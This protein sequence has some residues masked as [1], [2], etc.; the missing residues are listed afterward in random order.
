MKHFSKVREHVE[1]LNIIDDTLFQKM[2]ED[3][4]F[5]EEMISAVLSE[6]VQVVQSIPQGSVKNLQGRSVIVDALCEK[7][8]GTFINVEV[9]KN[10]DDNHQKRI[11]YNASCIT[12]NITDPGIKFEKVPDLIII[13]ISQFDMFK[14]KKIIYHVDRMVREMKTKVSNG[15][16]EIYV[17]TR[18]VDGSD[19]AELMRIYTNVDAYDYIKFPNTSKRKAHFKKNEEGVGIMC[20]IVEE[21]AQEQVRQ[22][23]EKMA[24]YAKEYAK[25]QVRETEGKMAK[26]L[27]KE[28]MPVVKIVSMMETLSVEDIKKLMES[29]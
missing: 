23:E 18:I 7:Q 1:R 5:C 20:D 12:A 11:R 10:N 13:Y 14:G 6:K 8:D 28:G 24:K 2:A 26:K 4:G 3:T 19:L 9:Q 16:E 15:M 25:E 27:L 29:N 17:N 22:T 21:Y